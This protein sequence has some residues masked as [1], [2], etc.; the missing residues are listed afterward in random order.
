MKRL[1][2]KVC[3]ITGAAKGIGQAIAEIF[4]Q[5]GGIVLISDID[6]KSGQALAKT[7]PQSEYHH[8]DVKHET[9]WKKITTYILD[10]YG[11]LDV[12]VNN[13][14]EF[15]P[16]PVGSINLDQI[17]SIFKTNV[18]APLLLTQ[19]ALPALRHAQGAVVNILDIYAG[20]V[21]PE[22]SVYCASKAALSMLTR[23]LALEC[24]PHVS[25][26]G[27][28]P[29][30]ILW[31]EGDSATSDEAKAAMLEKIPLRKTGSAD[32][33]AGAVSYLCSRDAEF[34]TGQTI[35]IDGGR[36]VL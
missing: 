30:A 35:V 12:L 21:H 23:S 27:V 1:D 26:N 19:A 11:R 2:Q 6:D 13:A 10:K 24:A 33:I 29:G 4:H 9:E 20:R 17:E 32:Q 14:S 7:L 5:E 8:L 34:I 25:V 15:F 28:A 16:T 36:T 18:F 3:L 22:H 31:P